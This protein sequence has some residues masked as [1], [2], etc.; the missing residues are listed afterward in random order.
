MLMPHLRT[1][2]L[3]I[4][5]SAI[6]GTL[7][8]RTA[9]PLPFLLGPMVASGMVATLLPHK[10]PDGYQF[11]Q[12]FRLVFMAIIGLMIGAQVTPA[13]FDKAGDLAISFLALIVFVATAMMFN[14][15]MFRRLGGYDRATAF[16]AGAP[17]GLYESIAL[18]EAAGADMPRLMLQQFLRVILVVTI[19]P[20]GLSF[21]LGAPVGSAAGLSLSHGPV[22]WHAL[23]WLAAAGALGIWIAR[24]MRLPAGQITGPLAVAA[25]LS[26]SGLGHLDVPQWLVNFAQIVIGTALGLRFTGLSRALIL[27]GATLAIVSVG[28][29]LLLAAAMALLLQPVLGEPFDVLLITFAP[30]G[31]TEMA[32]VALSLQ[33]N[34]AFVTL[35]HILRI[36]ITVIG[37]IATVRFIRPAL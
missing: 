29:M 37:M 19:L 23:P 24:V 27:H 8:T 11:P 12:R 15:L 2:T 1:T 18:G 16:Y 33:A 31:V 21:Y 25:I 9:M 35:H 28:G 14:Y 13:L 36:I 7:A 34:P 22:P 20:I 5:C 3:L 30:G 4:F 26:L 6:A 17:G 10:L 32:L